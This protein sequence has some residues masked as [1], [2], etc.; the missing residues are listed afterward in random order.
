MRPIGRTD[1]ARVSSRQFVSTEV[2]QK[3]ASPFS[4]AFRGVL[5][6]CE[7]LIERVR[8]MLN[9]REGDPAVPKLGKLRSKTSLETIREVVAAV[10]LLQCRW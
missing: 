7:T 1:W 9:D 5:A 2:G 4:R 10:G 3:P 8:E 6:G